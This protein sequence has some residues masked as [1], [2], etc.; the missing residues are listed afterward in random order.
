[1]PLFHSHRNKH[2]VQQLQT[3]LAKLPPPSASEP[4]S[5]ILLD[6]SSSSVQDG[7]AVSFASGS[8]SDVTR[9]ETVSSTG[10]GEG[11]KKLKHGHSLS[12]GHLS[13]GSSSHSASLKSHK[14]SGP[15]PFVL[16][17]RLTPLGL[18]QFSLETILTIPGYPLDELRN[19]IMP[20]LYHAAYSHRLVISGASRDVR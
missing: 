2:D 4:T 9:S 20:Q 5:P 11:E 16:P 10:S 19:E 15:P 3:D 6:S 14:S 8:G 7:R 17:A 18:V 12:I 1:M 13:R